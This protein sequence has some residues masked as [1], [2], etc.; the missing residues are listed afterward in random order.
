LFFA[1]APLQRTF[2]GALV[3]HPHASRDDGSSA[4]QEQLA[5]FSSPS[6]VGTVV[7]FGRAQSAVTSAARAFS[8]A[9]LADG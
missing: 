3:F 2:G 9:L 1:F 4:P 8:A 5:F 6:S 7:L